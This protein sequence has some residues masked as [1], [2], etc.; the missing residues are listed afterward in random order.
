MWG[1]GFLRAVVARLGWKW[2]VVSLLCLLW[3]AY[4]RLFAM[5]YD[6][7]ENIIVPEATAQFIETL[8]IRGVVARLQ[9]PQAI[10]FAYFQ[11]KQ[12]TASDCPNCFQPEF[13]DRIGRVYTLSRESDGNLAFFR[14]LRVCPIG[15]K[16][17]KSPGSQVSLLQV[18]ASEWPPNY[19]PETLKDSCV[20]DKIRGY[21][22]RFCSRTISN[23]AGVVKINFTMS[24]SY[25]SLD[26]MRFLYGTYPYQ[27]ISG[28]YINMV[29]ARV[30]HS[31]IEEF[32]DT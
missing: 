11:S 10:E 8:D 9:K 17:K 24:L 19:D 32:S 29:T 3:F 20:N 21:K 13:L 31:D 16:C 30:V 23:S 27:F 22:A 26:L 1:L 14:I 15:Q 6:Y 12:T 5:Q 4:P 28:V 25:P 7:R 18:P 2:I